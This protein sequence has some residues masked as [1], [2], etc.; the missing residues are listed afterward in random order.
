MMCT[1]GFERVSFRRKRDESLKLICFVGI[2]EIFVRIF[3]YSLDLSIGMV[4]C[5]FEFTN[6]DRPRKQSCE[7]FHDLTGPEHYAQHLR[8]ISISKTKKQ[9]PELRQQVAIG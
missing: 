7:L 8:V 3:G 1:A 6:R 4:G 9:T 2:I 5:S